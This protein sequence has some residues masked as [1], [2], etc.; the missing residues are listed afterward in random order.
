MD[1][2][3]VE[4]I[5]D[6]L[7][8]SEEQAIPI[9]QAIQREYRYLPEEALRLVCR[10]TQIQPSEIVGV[11]TFYSQ[12]RHVP[13]GRHHV[14]V[15][16]GTA[17]HVKGAVQVQDAL[18]QLL[19]IE[20]GTDT[21]P[22]GEYTV[23]KVACLGC[24]TLAPVVMIDGHTYGHLTPANVDQMI[25][26]FENNDSAF[27]SPLTLDDEIENRVLGEIRIGLGS[28][29]MAQGSRHALEA[30]LET[31]RENKAPVRVKRVG[32]VGMCHRA[33][34]MEI[35]LPTNPSAD[36]AP[37]KSKTKLFCQVTPESAREIVNRYFPSA[38]WLDRTRNWISRR[39]DQMY[40]DEF[41]DPVLDKF[42]NIELPTPDPVRAVFAGDQ[43]REAILGLEIDSQT[44]AQ[45]A[46]QTRGQAA[47]A[48]LGPQKHIATEFS[49]TLDPVDF[50]EYCSHEGFVGLTQARQMNPDDLIQQ[51]LD[52]GLRGRGGAGFPT[53]LKWRA[54]ANT[55]PSTANGT[56]T[57]SQSRPRYVVCNGDEGDPGAFM[58]RMLL[59]SFPYRVIEGMLIAAHAVRATEGYFYIR[60]EYPLAVERIRKAIAELES[61]NVLNGFTIH[62]KEGAGAF[63]CGE[64]TALLNSIEGRRGMPRLR[65][66]FPAQKGLWNYPTLVNNVETLAMISWIVRHGSGAFAQLGTGKSRGTKVFAL[67]GKIRRGGL[68]EVPM[69][70]TIGQ[71]VNEI[72]GGVANGKRFKAVQ[73]GGPSGGCIP[74]DLA[75]TPVDYEQLGAIG[76]IMGSGGMV[77][78]DENDC[79]VDI[80]RYFLQFTQ[81]QSCGKCTFCR[82]GTRRM[83]EILERICAGKGVPEDLDRLEQLARTVRDNSLCGLGKT[84][85]NPVL[86]TLRYFRSEYEAHIPALNP[87][88]IARCPAGKC[89]ALIAYNITD[90]CNGCTKCAQACPV[91]AVVSQPYQK[92][93][94]DMSKCTNCGTCLSVCPHQAIEVGDRK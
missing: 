30:V 19:K 62:V 32:C 46:T 57:G 9:L 49:G 58:D 3:P 77:V 42:L 45:T 27:S 73:V 29:C 82:I 13:M 2:T 60:A 85:P 15:C 67:A 14:C 44:N 59:E 26:D 90:R 1:L 68:I 37:G 54:V 87:D 48:F 41:P 28:C 61:R 94:I 75:Q 64:E 17:C 39:L 16:H 74:A 86:S 88:G 76:A 78:L 50:D 5:I 51:I 4:A 43:A 18:E 12:F 70:V 40:T 80:A 11:S 10:R 7:G 21:D 20:P 8:T 84:A 63:V 83:L 55:F 91:G 69:G 31:L 22:T 23:E 25:D 35:V 93:S 79:M 36:P 47:G 24:C 52:S 89:A 56:D 65:P 66:P 33:P 81:E 6:R 34:I 38:S 53:G 92:H 71:I 72:G